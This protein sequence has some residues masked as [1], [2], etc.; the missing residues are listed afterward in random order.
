MRTIYQHDLNYLTCLLSRGKLTDQNEK[1]LHALQE[2]IWV[3]MSFSELL[4]G[5]VHPEWLIYRNTWFAMAGNFEIDAVMFAGD[6]LY[7]FDIKNYRDSFTY[8]E[9]QIKRV[10]DGHIFPDIF[11]KLLRDKNRLRD[12]LTNSQLKLKIEAAIIF[13][14][15]DCHCQKLILRKFKLETV[16]KKSIFATFLKPH[17]YQL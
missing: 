15:V 2:G 8:M 14:N 4:D 1:D 12:E 17:H 5:W 3:E 6:T 7:L 13:V 10:E 11:T 9:Q 16:A